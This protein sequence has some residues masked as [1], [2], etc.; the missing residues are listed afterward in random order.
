MSPET[1]GSESTE[2]AEA[3]PTRLKSIT[4]RKAG[5]VRLTGVAHPLYGL[6]CDV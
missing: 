4:V 1:T 5:P 6:L 3:R 2:S